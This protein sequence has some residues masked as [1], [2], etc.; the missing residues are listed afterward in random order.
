MPK[1]ARAHTTKPASAS[2]RDLPQ[3]LSADPVVSIARE[4]QRLWDAYHGL[5]VAELEASQKGET[6]RETIMG[7]RRD[8]ITE[9]RVA[10]E[11]IGTYTVASSLPG[12]MIQM[13]WAMSDVQMLAGDIEAIER[14]GQ[15]KARRQ[16]VFR[17]NRAACEIG[18]RRD[19]DNAR[20][21]L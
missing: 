10:L 16:R 9:W 2:R 7:E 21:G 14:R 17:S 3:T 13:A 12:A 20:Q 15:G 8:Q 4:I 11:L 18:G 19:A 6:S 1:A 5:D